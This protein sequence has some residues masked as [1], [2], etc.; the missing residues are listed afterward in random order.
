MTI[1]AS[2]V[3]PKLISETAAGSKALFWPSSE[4]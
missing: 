1:M 3:S 2:Q 4:R